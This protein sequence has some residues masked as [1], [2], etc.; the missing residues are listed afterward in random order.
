MEL[1][2][3]QIVKSKAG[4]DKGDFFIIYSID[5]EYLYL[6]DGINRT[7]DKPKKKKVIHV[8]TTK[9]VDYGISD[10]IELGK[11]TN[12]EIKRAIK[13]YRQKNMHEQKMEV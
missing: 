2:A 9:F 7:V 11:I 5:N 13:L 3:G 12:E 6:T 4:H 10:K 1:K 8:Q